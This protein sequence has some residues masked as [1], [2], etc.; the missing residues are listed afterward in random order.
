MTR[1]DA[2]R[3]R[4]GSLALLNLNKL[5]P[6]LTINAKLAIAFALLTVVPLLAAVTV[7]TPIVLDQLRSAAEQTLEYNLD[8][9]HQG[10][11]RSIQEAEQH[12]SFVADAIIGDQ[13]SPT[14]ST[15]R[16]RATALAST[17]LRVDSSAVFRVRAF[18]TDARVRFDAGRLA[19]LQADPSTQTDGELLYLWTAE[20]ALSEGRLFLPVELRDP[21]SADNSFGVIPAIAILQPIRD[22]RGDLL[23]VAVAEA[24]ASALFQSLE[25]ATPGLKG[26]IGLVDMEGRF[27]YHSERKR[28]WAS[29]LA[30]EEA[31]NLRAE[32]SPD[33]AA[34]ILSGRPGTVRTEHDEFTSFRPITAVAAG[35]APL[36]L[37]RSVPLAAVNATVRKFLLGASAIGIAVLGLVLWVAVIAARQ[38]T[39][40][41]Y[42]LQRAARDLT[43]RGQTQPVLVET[44]DELEDLARDFTSMAESLVQHRENLETMVSA[45]TRAL[46]ET[47]AE[48]SEIVTHSADAI[49]GLDV[50]NRVRL[51]NDGARDLFGY[52]DREAIGEHIDRLIGGAEAQRKHESAYIERMLRETGSVVNLRT[53]RTPKDGPPFPVGLTQTSLTD[54]DRNPL[55]SSLIIRD[56]R[57]QQSLE[58]QMRRTERVAAV[59]I[60]AAGLAHELNNPLAILGNRIELMQRDAKSNGA[61]EQVQKDLAVLGH[62]V[63]R[64]RG[65]T[66]DLLGFAREDGDQSSRIE[67][68]E[69]LGRVIRLFQRTFTTKGIRL[70][71]KTDRG[72]HCITG[73]DSAIETVFVNLLL[74]ALQTTP[75]GGSVS[76]ECRS[77][78]DDDAFVVV[79][80]R[81]TGPGIPK[82]IQKRIFEPFFT[83]KGDK[84]G[85]G[86]GLAVCRTIAE[87]H[88]GSIS[89]ESEEG[90]G[91]RFLVS[92]PTHRG[93]V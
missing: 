40:P 8:L 2:E 75:Q 69:I 9:V 60:M 92:L 13:L 87:R 45:R 19:R 63:Q 81:D 24:T 52:E 62:H 46:Q 61:S 17:F 29:L 37:Y 93:A 21:A 33:V 48:L 14:P 34:A 11:S 12:L 68:E 57:M 82:D 18:D 20:N 64:L 51:W 28:D 71:L 43:E 79:E 89:I 10:V 56:H 86:L 6:R 55:G 58:D 16:A 7:A 73:H 67:L 39:K 74:N 35:G 54:E 47:R 36:V 44:N 23:G 72:P 41:I 88:G 66:T 3:P 53:V 27:L 42:L 26:A 38:F 1:L 85:T 22:A 15:D 90:S 49:I 83:T 80:V 5:T 65:V 78:G 77:R 59:S 91:S 32:F 25:L 50:D 84:G 70:E 30:A 4:R 31:T 76:V